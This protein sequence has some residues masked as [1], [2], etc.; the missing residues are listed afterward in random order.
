MEHEAEV[1]LVEA[2]AQRGGG[3]ERLDLVVPQGRLEAHSLGGLGATCVGRDGVPGLAQRHG[4]VLGGSDRQGIDDARAGQLAQVGDEPGEALLRC[5]EGQHAETQGRARQG[6]PEG[7]DVS[8][9]G[10]ELLDDVGDDASVGGRGRGEHGGAVGE[11]RQQVA[12]AAVVGPEVVAP[13]TDAV[14]LVDDEQSAGRGERRKLLVAEAR[15]V[16]SLGADEEHVHLTA[17]QGA[18][19]GPPL[20]GVGGVEGHRTDAGALGRGDLV[21]HEREQRAD[22]DGR[23]GPLGPPQRRRDEVDGRLAPPGALH[24]EH[25]AA[26]LDELGDRLELPLAEVDVVAA[27]QPP[28]RGRRALAQ[29]DQDGGGG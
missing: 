29:V 14:R 13:V 28:Q 15:V 17:R 3:D 20:V 8:P 6:P 12:D 16:E 18:G 23:T 24:D 26:P 5:G 10:P 4:D 25:P 27:H 19:D 9:A 21:A 22:D 7:E 2:H 1:G 11:R